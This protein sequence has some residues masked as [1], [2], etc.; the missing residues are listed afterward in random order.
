MNQELL[1]LQ[2]YDLATKMS[3]G[4]R[5]SHREAFYLVSRLYHTAESLEKAGLD[6]HNT[7]R[8]LSQ[9][10]DNSKKGDSNEVPNRTGR[11]G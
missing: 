6:F 10:D 9:Y 7:L 2:L 11:K 3:L 4:R 1:E 5:M 8:V